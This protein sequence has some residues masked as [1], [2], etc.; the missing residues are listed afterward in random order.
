LNNAAG[1]SFG[2]GKNADQAVWVIIVVGSQLP[3]RCTLFDSDKMELTYLDWAKGG[4]L[5]LYL[6]IPGGVPGLETKIPGD[7]EPWEYR[8]KIADFQS[9]PCSFEGYK[10]FLY[11]TFLLP[12]TYSFTAQ[13]LDIYVNY[14]D[15]P[16]F[17]QH[18]AYLPKMQGTGDD[19]GEAPGPTC[20]M[21]TSGYCIAWDA[22]CAC[23][24][25]KRYG[26]AFGSCYCAP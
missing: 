25:L 18:P 5:T 12:E 22:Y 3:E 15:T 11:C 26:I 16:F 8:G 2:V 4:A 17:S 19:A 6:T 10:E 1:K 14:C 20:T 7:D 9:Q 24:G 23:L 13:N 21:P